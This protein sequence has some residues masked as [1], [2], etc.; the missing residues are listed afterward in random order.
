LFFANVK[1]KT[2][3]LQGGK[4]PFHSCSSIIDHGGG[5]L[6]HSF[7]PR[8]FHDPFHLTM[9][10]S[11][12][13]LLPLETDVPTPENED[14]LGHIHAATSPQEQ[15][16]ALIA[17]SVL[18]VQQK[19]VFG[20]GDDGNYDPEA[21]RESQ[22]TTAV[23]LLHQVVVV[24]PASRSALE[25]CVMACGGPAVAIQAAVQTLRD[26]SATK[27]A[28]QAV[29]REQPALG[30]KSPPVA[31]QV[32]LSVL[33]QLLCL[34]PKTREEV[35]IDQVMERVGSTA[36]A[37]AIEIDASSSLEHFVTL[38]TVLPSLVAN[39]C[40]AQQCGLAA[41]AVP[42]RFRSRLVECASSSVIL[43]LQEQEQQ[44][45]VDETNHKDPNLSTVGGK[46]SKDIVAVQ[47]FQML[48]QRMVRHHGGEDVAMGWYREFQ[49]LLLSGRTDMDSDDAHE[50]KDA[51][52]NILAQTIRDTLLHRLSPRESAM[53]CRAIFRHV[54][55]LQ[56]EQEQQKQVPPVIVLDLKTVWKHPWIDLSC[57][58]AMASS[59]KIRDAVIRLFILSPSSVM[60]D[61]SCDRQLCHGVAS[62]LAS[63]DSSSDYDHND[64]DETDVSSDND[65]ETTVTATTDRVLRK[66]LDEVAAVW[67]QTVFV[68]QTDR[69]MQRHVTSFLLSG[70]ALLSAAQE[71][72]SAD[73]V[74][75]ILEGVT[76]R[77]HSTIDSIRADGMQVGERLAKR[78][79]QELQFDELN[80]Q[81]QGDT[82]TAPAPKPT[83]EQE[84]SQLVQDGATPRPTREK[85]KIPRRKQIDPDA[86][87]MSEQEE[88]DGDD[89][90]ASSSSGLD[91]DDDSV[92]EDDNLI[93][94]DLDDDEEDLR[95]TARPLYLHECIE[96]LRTAETE[97]N[98]FSSH[99]AALK[100]L[101]ALVRSRPVDLPDIS[102]SLAIELLRMENKFNIQHFSEMLL[103]SIISLAVEDPLSVG[104]TLV[105]QLFQEGSLF[106]RLTALTSLTE[107]AI[108]LSGEKE[109]EEWRRE[110]SRSP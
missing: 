63:V 100:E 8:T 2:L 59:R 92:W 54:L 19:N 32:S 12:T 87:Y 46:D 98:A 23:R 60:H 69:K 70:M 34:R 53:L 27:A 35:W 96:L 43:L 64:D 56:Q 33:H 14:L 40:H 9:S 85:R 47:Y 37:T 45:H 51:A 84:L 73:L 44:L 86:E 82:L 38:V 57:L 71:D 49:R 79:G 91:D 5:R 26:V 102:E 80:S 67:S 7:T 66:H 42:A 109:L 88:N 78:L 83:L 50:T 10:L 90:D 24:G 18:L 30:L 94:Y 21:L 62:L 65:E 11:S 13:E 28:T 6:I 55:S 108:E 106:N 72:P 16:D 61:E 110:K 22:L 95:E 29:A 52:R 75:N 74:A 104:Q 77:L 103:S 48:V 31:L 41:W 101:P 4:R 20:I 93:A 89:D 105:A 76:A 99:E 39:A 58:P 3:I 81:R 36:T 15:V 1:S 107:A 25:S 68:R 17:L 97:D